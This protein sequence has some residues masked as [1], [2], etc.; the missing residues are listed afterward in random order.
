MFKSTGW[1]CALVLAFMSSLPAAVGQSVPP[2]VPYAECFVS[3]PPDQCSTRWAK[4]K[5]C[6]SGS[7][8]T[9]C[10]DVVLFHGSLPQVKAA[11]AGET[12]KRG[13]ESSAQITTVYLKYKCLTD[14]TCALQGTWIRYCYGR[15]PFGSSC[16]GT[17]E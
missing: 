2:D 1:P 6:T 5:W 7:V 10:H 3:A 9:D 12:G 17:L 11:G 13:F 16:E 8:A 14:N 4:R 15:V